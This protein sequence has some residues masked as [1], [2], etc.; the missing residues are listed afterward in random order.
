VN[1]VLR[2]IALVSIVALVL[3]VTGAT[4]N[5]ATTPVA[6]PAAAA[7][8]SKLSASERRAKGSSF[9]RESLDQSAFVAASD[10]KKAEKQG[11][12]GGTLLRA[13]FGLAVVIGAIFGVQ[14]LLKKWAA[15]K[16]DG[17]G[18]AAGLIDVVA[19][20]GLSQ[21]RSL[22]LVRVADELV[23]VGSTEHSISRLGE[24]DARQ[25]V[26]DTADA[27]S[28]FAL[29]SA[30]RRALP[31]ATGPTPINDFHG[32]LE[33]SLAGPS[34]LPSA[35]AQPA[36]TEGSFLQRFVHNLRMQTAR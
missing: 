34:R 28:T 19:T 4:A 31:A 15:A 33:G 17:V 11:S 22:H 8:Q 13:L 26:G 7:K 9:E 24:F 30:T 32:M 1:A 5:A 2:H 14:W 25:L 20:T 29:P 10:S 6:K 27:N 12:G 3:T 23:L 21:G 36:A 16:M 35:A 18:G